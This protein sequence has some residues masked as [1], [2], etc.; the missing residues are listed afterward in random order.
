[1]SRMVKNF[2]YRLDTVALYEALDSKRRYDG[3]SWRDVADEIGCT[4]NLFTRMKQNGDNVGISS[5]ALMSILVWLGR[6]DGFDDL[7]IRQ[8][9]KEKQ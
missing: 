2:T 5:Y 3:L 6:L 8:E 4:S 1:M 9:R 7:V